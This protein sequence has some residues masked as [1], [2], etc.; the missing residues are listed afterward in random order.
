MCVYATKSY[1]T[2][3]QTSKPPHLEQLYLEVYEH[4]GGKRLME[5][6]KHHQG[7]QPQSKKHPCPLQVILIRYLNH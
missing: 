3:H 2:L 1:S 6:T 7:N 5:D 4:T